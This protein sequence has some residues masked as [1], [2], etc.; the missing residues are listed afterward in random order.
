MRLGVRLDINPNHCRY[1]LCPGWRR[2][3]GVRGGLRCLCDQALQPKAIVGK[4]QRISGL[5]VAATSPRELIE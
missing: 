2:R 5:I 3:K 4:N 1:V